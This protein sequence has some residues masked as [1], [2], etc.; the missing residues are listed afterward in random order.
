MWQLWVLSLDFVRESSTN[1]ILCADKMSAN[2][3]VPNRNFVDMEIIQHMFKA[4]ETIKVS[5]NM[6]QHLRW[7]WPIEIFGNDIHPDSFQKKEGMTFFLNKVSLSN[8]AS[9]NLRNWGLPWSINFQQIITSLRMPWLGTA[10]G[11]SHWTLGV[12]ASSPRKF[13]G[14]GAVDSKK[15]FD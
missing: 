11:S 7:R 8:I 9:S 12:E 6:I 3:C 4:L 13:P 15:L 14:F 10:S 5:S 2:K 1:K